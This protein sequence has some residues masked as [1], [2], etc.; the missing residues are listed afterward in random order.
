MRITAIAA[1][2]LSL[3]I[4]APVWAAEGGQPPAGPAPNFDER[5]AEIL[6]KLNEQMTS[7]QEAK[8]CIQAAKNHDDM[9]ACREKHMA[10]TKQL[11]EGM[12]KQGRPGGQQNQ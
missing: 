3:A 8:S 12:K 11:R 5:K 1:V 7:L 6:K 4:A 2:V 9:R 10:E